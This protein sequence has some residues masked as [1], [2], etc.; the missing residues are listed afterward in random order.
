MAASGDVR[1]Q[2]SL[3]I[4]SSGNVNIN[5]SVK[6]VDNVHVSIPNLPNFLNA[7]I[8]PLLSW[9]CEI[10]ADTLVSALPSFDVTIPDVIPS[11]ISIGG[12]P[13]SVSLSNFNYTGFDNNR[14]FLI[15]ADASFS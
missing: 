8:D 3:S 10:I 2:G 15:M 6:S 9:I 11:N 12:I 5:F 4:D 13:L 14:S 1:I 7:V